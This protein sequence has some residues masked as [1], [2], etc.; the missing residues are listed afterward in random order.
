MPKFVQRN[1][2]EWRGLKRENLTLRCDWRR[3]SRSILFGLP[4]GTRHWERRSQASKAREMP[5]R[6]QCNDL[7]SATRI[8]IK[9]RI[10]FK[11]IIRRDPKL[12]QLDS[13]S[14]ERMSRESCDQIEK[15][16]NLAKLTKDKA[17]ADR[18]DYKETIANPSLTPDEK[19]YFAWKKNANLLRLH[20]K[21]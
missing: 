17:I 4:R 6:K 5:S 14:A 19:D 18:E 9:R 10:F 21:A 1:T 16:L 13:P 8:Q 7:K 20:R 11:F 15:Y 3:K 12:L 2:G